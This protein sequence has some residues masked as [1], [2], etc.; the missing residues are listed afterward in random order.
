MS[1]LSGL[2]QRGARAVGGDCDAEQV[3][4]FRVVDGN[5]LHGVGTQRA[6]ATREGKRKLQDAGVVACRDDLARK[7]AFLGET[8]SVTANPHWEAAT[9]A[10]AKP[11]KF[12]VNPSVFLA[13]KV[14]DLKTFKPKFN[15][16]DGLRRIADGYAG[17]IFPNGDANDFIDVKATPC[18]YFNVEGE[19]GHFQSRPFQ[20]E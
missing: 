10:G 16:C 2:E 20:N 9:Y 7:R 18:Y 8:I 4:A 15:R 5:A 6:A 1:G 19:E 11:Q 14:A 12:D 13:G 3:L 17:G